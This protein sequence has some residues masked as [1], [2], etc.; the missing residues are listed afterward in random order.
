VVTLRDKGNVSLH[1]SSLRILLKL[2]TSRHLVVVYRHPQLGRVLTLNDEIQHVEA[3]APLYHEPLVHLPI[4]FVA[5]PRTALVVGGGSFFAVHELLKYRSIKRV[6]V[7]DYDQ[8]LLDAICATYNHAAVARRDQRVEVRAKNAFRAFTSLQERFD[9]VINDSVDL[10]RTQ[11]PNIFAAMS[12]LLRRNGVCSD[13]VYRHVFDDRGLKRTIR[14][15]RANH[16]TV[17]SMIFAPEYPGILHLLTIW[18][19]NKLLNQKQE[20]TLNLEQRAWANSP[21]RNPCQYFDARFLKYYLH[22]P[23]YL[24]SQ[25][26]EASVT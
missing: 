22:L 19:D 14:L 17:L 5:A 24:R 2:R 11:G 21:N 8:E 7:M 6:L 9:V 4:A 26:T 3:W 1:L 20:K 15:L 18:S 12:R 13:V 10:F 23:A 25:L 16:N